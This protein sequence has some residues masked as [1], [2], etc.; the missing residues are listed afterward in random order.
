MSL[1]LGTDP[2][3]GAIAASNK[4]E[5]ESGQ[6]LDDPG[7]DESE[8]ER[9]DRNLAD[10]LQEMRVAGLGVQVLFGFMLSL[11]FTRRF[12]A[13]SSTE[14]DIY[15]TSLLLAALATALLC[16]PVAFHRWVFRRHE[17][18]RLVRMAN[19]MVLCGLGAVGLAISG[20]VLLVVGFVER[21][22]IV[23]VV[24]MAVVVVYGGLWFALPLVDR[25]RHR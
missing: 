11:P 5:A 20:A 8:E 3:P 21:G 17:K 18:E 13:L 9:A 2:S 14:R 16:A 12:T 10:L 4:S 7:R 25:A 24:V 1:S 19:T 15:L 6:A 23:P 22:V